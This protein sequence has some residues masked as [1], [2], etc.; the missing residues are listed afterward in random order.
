MILERYKIYYLFLSCIIIVK[1]INKQYIYG[2]Q[3]KITEK[4]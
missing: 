2:D 3:I 4:K 1:L